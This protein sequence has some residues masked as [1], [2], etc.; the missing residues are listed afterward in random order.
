MT[1]IRFLATAPLNATCRAAAAEH[2]FAVCC[3][4]HNVFFKYA[5]MD[6]ASAGAPST[7][8]GGSAIS[9][10]RLLATRLFT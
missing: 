3:R 5:T 7:A 1:P 9:V 4:F 6:G 2:L 10:H 8:A